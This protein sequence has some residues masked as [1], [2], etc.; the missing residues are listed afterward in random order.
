MIAK[1]LWHI[2]E[3]NTTIIEE[4]ILETEQKNVLIN[5]KYSFISSGTETLVSRGLVPNELKDK[6]TV[7]YMGGSFNFPVKYGYSLVGETGDGRNVHL[8]HPHQDR[9]YA[10]ESDLYIIPPGLPLKRAALLS[11]METTINAVWDAQLKGDEKVLVIGFGGVGALLALTISRYTNI[12]PC[13][14]EPDKDK[15]KKAQ[16]LGFSFVAGE[17]DV[18]FHT[19]AS[20]DGLQYAIDHVRK[21][22]VVMELSWYGNRQVNLSLG[23]N[24]HYN[25]VKL[26][27]SQVSV[28]SPFAP[29]KGYKERK[30]VACTILLDNVFDEMITNEIGFNDLP[31]YFDDL[32]INGNKPALATIVKY[33]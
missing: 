3:S 16:G 32:K 4:E 23:G 21:D 27:S 2:D 28:V 17:Y 25:R 29:I 18:I 8:M 31:A 13:V 22:G 20:N 12:N 7:N 10:K 30:D 9:L 24:F 5:T 1:A 15:M 19:S 26:I 14:M 11:N 6:M 33:I